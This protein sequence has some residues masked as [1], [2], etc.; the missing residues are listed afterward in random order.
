MVPEN[1]EWPSEHFQVLDTIHINAYNQ[2]RHYNYVLRPSDTL[3]NQRL[4]LAYQHPYQYSYYN[5][6]IDELQLQHHYYGTLQNTFTSFDS[7]HFNLTSLQ[8]GADSVE[9]TLIGGGETHVDTILLSDIHNFGL[10]GLDT[11]TLYQC[12]VRPLSEGCH[13]Y[14]GYV[15]TSAYGGSGYGN[16][17]PFSYELSYE[18][19]YHWASD[20]TTLITTGDYLQ[21]EPHGSVAMHPMTGVQDASFL[22]RASSSVAGDTLLL[23]SIPSDSISADSTHF[24]PQVAYFTPIDTFVLGTDWEYYMLRLPSTATESVRLTFRAGN[25]VTNLDEIE[26]TWCPIVHFTVD[27][28]SIV[29]TLDDDQATNYYLTLTDSAG[30]DQRVIFVENN[31]YRINGLHK[32]TRYD[33]SW[34]GW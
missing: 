21:L 19:P 2:R 24:G 9:I 26:I 10:G 16:C 18:L 32:N 12:Y 15:V 29:C 33:L 3:F 7:V 22:F 1:N 4:V 17:F 11:G 6:Y 23:G 27:G 25:G 30:T 31:P 20:S 13:S 28:N 5:C 8:G 14:A 34:Q